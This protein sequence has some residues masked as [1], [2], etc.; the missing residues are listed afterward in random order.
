MF[1]LVL[2]SED[3]EARTVMVK[4]VVPKELPAKT[5]SH[6]WEE[7]IASVRTEM[8]FYAEL[9]EERN[10][11]IRHLFPTVHHSC[12]T[13]VE[14]DSQPMDTEFSIIMQDLSLDYFQKPMMT[15]KEARVVL[16]SLADMHS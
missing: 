13:P 8:Q 12:G 9:R 16:Q 2:Q 10:T 6:I 15:E 5:G 11:G 4:R 14:S 7:F 1:K 3:G